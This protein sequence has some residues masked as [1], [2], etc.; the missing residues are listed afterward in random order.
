MTKKT[1]KIGLW[2]TDFDGTIKPVNPKASVAPEDLAALKRL[3]DEGWARAVVT[4]RSLFSFATAWE[5]GLELDWLIFSSGSGLCPWGVLGPGAVL[6]T[7]SFRPADAENALR[8]ALELNFG[9]FAYLPPPDSHHF[10]YLKPQSMV[11]S[12][13]N[14]RLKM[15]AAQGRLFL[16]D[17]FDR[18]PADRPALGQLLLMVPEAEAVRAEAELVRQL[19]HLSRLGSASP[20]GDGCRWLEV[21]P[22]GVS[23]GRA[24]AALVGR[25]GLDRNRTVALGNDHN[26]CDLLDWAGQAFV[27]RDAPPDLLSRHQLIAPAGQG[28][29]A[30]AV[31]RVLDSHMI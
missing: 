23:K 12:G 8:T 18:P 4:G 3:K 7:R 27:T 6:E 2:L 11:P 21:L 1:D 15:F 17:Y 26:D 25:L 19:P 28:G 24:A 20:F 29:L 22:P 13:F 9:F 30:Q 31:S 10:Y 5:P 16:E 14:K